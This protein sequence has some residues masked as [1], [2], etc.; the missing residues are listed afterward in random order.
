MYI[1]PIYS[2]YQTR[3]AFESIILLMSVSLGT[4]P[5]IS[6]SHPPL[7]P[8]RKQAFDVRHQGT[9]IGIVSKSSNS[10]AKLIFSESSGSHVPNSLVCLFNYAVPLPHPPHN[11]YFPTLTNF[12]PSNNQENKV[13]V[14]FASPGLILGLEIWCVGL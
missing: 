3:A 5:L 10:V 6:H 4:A 8:I 11:T 13:A 9:R 2:S 7:T 1:R 12:Q 14:G